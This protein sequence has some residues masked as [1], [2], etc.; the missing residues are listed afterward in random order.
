VWAG[1]LELDTRARGIE[2]GKEGKKTIVAS[3]LSMS[4]E[5]VGSGMRR[6][7]R[8]PGRGD[9]GQAGRPISGQP[10]DGRTHRG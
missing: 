1:W 2:V 3:T 9:P 5:R 4:C 8:S 7:G 10:L 6:A